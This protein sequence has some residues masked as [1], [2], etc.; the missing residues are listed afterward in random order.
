MAPRL[1][2]H[3]DV[4]LDPG[5]RSNWLIEPSASSRTTGIMM[6]S[7]RCVIA[8]CMDGH[9]V[10]GTTG[11]NTSLRASCL[12]DSSWTLSYCRPTIFGGFASLSNGAAPPKSSFNDGIE[13]EGPFRPTRTISISY[14][15]NSVRKS[16]ISPSFTRWMLDVALK[17]SM[18]VFSL[19]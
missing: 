9:S 11:G 3:F 18:S 19:V 4:P 12:S 15:N 6:D 10:D 14:R 16:E 2:G 13:D 1:V 8:Q 5:P 17:S 7:G